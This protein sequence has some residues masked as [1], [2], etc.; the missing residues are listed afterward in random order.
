MNL[1]SSILLFAS[2]SFVT[3]TEEAF[4][5]DPATSAEKMAIKESETP[6]MPDPLPKGW[7]TYHLAHPGPGSA[8][9]GDPNVAIY[10]NGRYHLRR[11]PGHRIRVERPL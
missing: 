10:H 2:F 5:N 11:S 8:I 3:I 9:P 6:R 4:L 7:V 1:R